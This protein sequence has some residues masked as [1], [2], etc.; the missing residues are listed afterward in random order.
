M[1]RGYRVAVCL[2][3][4]EY[5]WRWTVYRYAPCTPEGENPHRVVETGLSDGRVEAMWEGVKAIA[6]DERMEDERAG[7]WDEPGIRE[8]ARRNDDHMAE[9]RASTNDD[10]MAGERAVTKDELRQIERAEVDE[11]TLT[12]VR[13]FMSDDRMEGVRADRTGRK[14]C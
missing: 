13:A 8:R 1:R 2:W 11:E 4:G 3:D 5:V 9:E 6:R 7:T 10:H 14:H 12:D